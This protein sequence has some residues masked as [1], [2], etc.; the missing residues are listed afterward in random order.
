YVGSSTVNPATITIDNVSPS[1][2]HVLLRYLYGQNI[3]VAIW[4]N[5]SLN[6]NKLS[7]SENLELHKNILE[8]ANDYELDHLKDLMELK[9]SHLVNKSNMLEMEDLAR[10]LNANQLE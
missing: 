3:D 5:Q 1:S 9:L 7:N 6:G 2:V 10:D 8:L 4:N